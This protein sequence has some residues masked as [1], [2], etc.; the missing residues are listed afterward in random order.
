MKFGVG[1]WKKILKSNCLPGK[2]VGQIYMQTQRIL[3]QQSLGEF[4]GI[5]IDA[6][7]V[8]AA[9]KKK[10]NVIRKNNFIV[11]QNDNLTKE[12]KKILIE[13]NKIAFGADQDQISRII[14]P[15]YRKEAFLSL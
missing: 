9:N 8:L 10:K 15:R 13:Q 7:K 4:M 14:L 6:D 11:N 2:S 3:G 1:K 5:H 12:E